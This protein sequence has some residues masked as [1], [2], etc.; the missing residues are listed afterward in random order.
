M[1][2]L[3]LYMTHLILLITITLLKVGSIIIPIP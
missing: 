3:A 2:K 1:N